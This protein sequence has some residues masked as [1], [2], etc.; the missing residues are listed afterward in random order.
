[1]ITPLVQIVLDWHAALNAR[2]V[3]RL[4]SLSTEDVEVGGPRGVGK[5]VD[6]LRDWVARAGIRM[7]PLKWHAQGNSVVV[8][9]RAQWQTPDGESTQLQEVASV[10]R[11][12]DGRVI[13]IIRYADFEAALD[14]AG[15]QGQV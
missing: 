14:A 7:E 4:V 1:M 10:F 9:E 3:D 5:G 15:M 12:E 13:S 8:L 2:D 11:V 6:L